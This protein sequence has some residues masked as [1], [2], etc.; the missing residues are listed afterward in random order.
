MERRDIR[1]ILVPT[2]LSESS[3]PALRLARLLA[4]RL[5]A[6]LTVMFADL[7]TY[8]VDMFT[9][10]PVV[11]SDA[12]VEE[13]QKLRG[14]IALRLQE[15][16]DG[17]PFDVIV[18]TG[19]PATMILHAAALQK[20][21][22]IVMGTHGRRGVAHALLGSVAEKVVRLAPMPVLTVHGEDG[23]NLASNEA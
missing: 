10:T 11:Y 19:Q 21:D 18:L 16:L 17:R 13:Y 6:S 3:V 22:L 12:G 1:S 4:D 7:T 15:W 5:G 2:D 8:P 14:E 23:Q 9:D 20:T